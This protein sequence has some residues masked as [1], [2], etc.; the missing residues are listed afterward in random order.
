M[1][2]EST[3][4]FDDFL[5]LERRAA[6]VALAAPGRDPL[7]YRELGEWLPDTRRALSQAGVRPG[8]VTA[9]ALP[10]GPELITAFLAISGMGA[11]APLD[12]SL[13]EDEYRFYLARLGA[14]TLIVQDGTAAAAASAAGA[15]GM[16][17]LRIQPNLN[18]P[19]GIFTVGAARD[20]AAPSGRT[21]NAVPC[22]SFHIRDHGRA[23]TGSAHLGQPARDGRARSARCS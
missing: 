12:P 21:T 17:V 14:R 19:A 18:G 6:A 7:T 9:V 3:D 8:E 16:R 11:C 4:R 13:T 1:A 10:N 20:A 22:C 5:P 2:A 23:Q 15:L